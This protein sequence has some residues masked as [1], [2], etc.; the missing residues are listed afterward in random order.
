MIAFVLGYLIHL[1]E[2]MPTPASSWGGV[3]LL[4]PTPLY[5]GGWGDIW[6]W[7][8]YDIFLIV[9]SVI[10][11]NLVLLLMN[12]LVHLHVRK[13]TLGVF[14]I[15]CTLACVQIKTRPYDFAYS[16][17]THRYE[18]LETQSKQIQKGILGGSLYTL[19]EE[20][21]NKLKIYF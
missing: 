8:N 18:V 16:G 6:W 5:T 21:D 14:I 9:C 10:L 3:N 12:N 7:S 17:H 13:L 4:W 11:L 1:V 20:F 19:L 15:G 2:D